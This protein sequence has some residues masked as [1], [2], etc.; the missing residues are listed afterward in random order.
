MTYRIQS[1]RVFF[2]RNF[3]VRY[4][5]YRFERGML[6][7]TVILVSPEESKNMSVK[8]GSG[9]L[10]GHTIAVD[11]DVL[12]ELARLAIDLDTVVEELLKG[13][14]VENTIAGGTGVVDRELVLSSSGLSSGGLTL[15]RE[16]R[17]KPRLAY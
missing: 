15:R 3:F 2:L 17:G 5:R 14:A 12:T 4:L 1:R 10:C 8:R 13:R 6:E 16:R 9:K 11:L 7:V